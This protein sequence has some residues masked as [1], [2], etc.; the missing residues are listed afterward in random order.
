MIPSDWD[1]RAA[2]RTLIL[3]A[4]T[5]AVAW[6]NFIL[7]VIIGDNANALK[8]TSGADSGKIHGWMIGEPAETNARQGAVR[9]DDDDSASDNSKWRLDTSLTYPIWFLHY[10][11]H[12]DPATGHSSAK[13]FAERRAA[14]V[15]KFAK[16]PRL[17]IFGGACAGSN[18]IKSHGELQATERPE[19]I[20]MG[21]EWAHWVGYSL[22]V[23]LYRTPAG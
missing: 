3:A 19:L 22:R 10:Y 23:D 6:P 18:Q 5:T 14:V 21:G 7:D 16:K 17:G 20:A 9:W 15:E 2:I 4:D 13:L 8:P 1:I 11:E 12:G